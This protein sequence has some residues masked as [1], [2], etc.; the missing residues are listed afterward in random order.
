MFSSRVFSV[1]NTSA[2]IQDAREKLKFFDNN[3]HF[4]YCTTTTLTTSCS[5]NASKFAIFH[6]KND[7]KFLKFANVSFLVVSST[8]SVISFQSNLTVSSFLSI[9]VFGMAKLIKDKCLRI[10][11]NVLPTLHAHLSCLG[12]ERSESQ[13]DC[14]H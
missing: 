4:V 7:E 6:E 2:I 11:I 1:F 13:S 10:A 12:L 5:V 9:R 3:Q 14:K 8:Y